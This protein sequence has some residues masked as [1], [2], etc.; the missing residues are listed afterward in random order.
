MFGVCT[1]ISSVQYSSPTSGYVVLEEININ[2]RTL[3]LQLCSIRFVFI[4]TLGVT[5][6]SGFTFVS[7]AFEVFAAAWNTT[8]TP[9]ETFLQ[10][11]ASRKSP[12]R[13]STVSHPSKSFRNPLLQLVERRLV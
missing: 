10:N 3:F 6:S 1:F 4:S 2:L 12:F 13:C 8:S 7:N 5:W 9:S 11:S